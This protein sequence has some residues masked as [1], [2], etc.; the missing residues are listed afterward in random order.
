[1][2]SG[3]INGVANNFIWIF[4]KF[5]QKSTFCRI[6]S[7]ITLHPNKLRVQSIYENCSSAPQLYNEWLTNAR[8][9][10]YQKIE[11]KCEKMPKIWLL[12]WISLEDHRKENFFLK[13]LIIRIPHTKIDKNRTLLHSARW[14]LKKQKSQPCF[15]RI[16]TKPLN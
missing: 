5:D 4:Q 6:S 10:S 9:Y 11:Q 3:E 14:V 12:W 8:T 13:F 1:M 15:M 16:L 2:W 7:S